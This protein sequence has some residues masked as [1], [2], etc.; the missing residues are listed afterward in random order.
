MIKV[1][2]KK[3]INR[4]SANLAET[5]QQQQKNHAS[6]FALRGAAKNAAQM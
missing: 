5:L 6:T 3:L 2:A 4:T 1:K